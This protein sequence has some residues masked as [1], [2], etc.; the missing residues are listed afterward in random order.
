MRK[1]HNGNVGFRNRLS[2]VVTTASR[3]SREGLRGARQ[4]IRRHPKRSALIGLGIA[5]LVGGPVYALIRRSRSRAEET[6]E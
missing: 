2:G 6:E 1:N 4:C 3:I 5:V